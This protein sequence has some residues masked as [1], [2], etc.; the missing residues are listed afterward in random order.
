MHRF[1]I[2]S[3]RLVA[4]A[5]CLRRRGGHRGRVRAI[6]PAPA[7]Q[8]RDDQRLP[9]PG[10]WLRAVDNTNGC[11]QTR[12]CSELEHD[13]SGGPARS[14]RSGR[15]SRR[16]RAVRPARPARRARCEGRSRT[17]RRSGA[18]RARRSCRSPRPSRPCRASR[19]RASTRSTTSTACSC[20]GGAGTVDLTFGGANEAVFTCVPSGGGDEAERQRQRV[21]DWRH[22]R[23]VERVRRDRE[24]RAPRPPISRD[25]SSSTGPR[26]E[27]ATSS[28]RPSPTAR[29]SQQ[30]ASSSSAAPAMQAGLLPTRASRRASPRRAEA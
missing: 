27:Q 28:S 22:R 16:N 14:S 5:V 23:S 29:R 6:R 20:N 3:T 19:S 21:D 2:R 4:I 1:P 13:R 8:R 18:C 30:A 17:A 11:K 24:H 10:G 25:G 12:T 7:R 26:P 15:P 9:A